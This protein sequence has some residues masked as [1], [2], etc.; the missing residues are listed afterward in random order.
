MSTSIFLK[1]ALESPT[2]NPSPDTL[3]ERDCSFCAMVCGPFGK[4]SRTTPGGDT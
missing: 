1:T 4:S 3:K 2:S